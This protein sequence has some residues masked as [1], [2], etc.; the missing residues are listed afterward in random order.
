MSDSLRGSI[1]LTVKSSDLRNGEYRFPQPITAKGLKLHSAYIPVTYRT[2]DD[3]HYILRVVQQ[4]P[5]IPANIEIPKGN[6]TV[7]ELCQNIETQL[8]TLFAGSTWTVDFNSIISRVTIRNNTKTFRIEDHP[9]SIH[10]I[11]GLPIDTQ[12]VIDGNYKLTG[13][14]PPNVQNVNLINV[15]S[16]VLG[17]ACQDCL[18]SSYPNNNSI[19]GTVHMTNPYGTWQSHRWHFDTYQFFDSNQHPKTLYGF[20]L[21]LLDESMR[22]IDFQGQPW[23]VELSFV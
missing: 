18:H 13:T 4:S 19:L 1:H 14:M 3:N 7:V 17:N 6:Y 11:L 21:S 23:Y 20:D 22:D 12:P 10:N 8:N 16:S 9:K 2:I 5:D 15:V